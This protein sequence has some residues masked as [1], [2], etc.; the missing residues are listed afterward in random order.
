MAEDYRTE[1]VSAVLPIH[2]HGR[3]GDARHRHRG[4]YEAAEAAAQPT[5]DAA[6]VASILGL[7]ESMVTPRVLDA[8]AGLVSEIER[9]RWHDQQFQRREQYLEQ[10]S[11]RHSVV[12]A[13][14]R[15]AFVRE[16]ECF[17]ATGQPHGVLV[18][19]H[20]D[21]IERLAGVQGLAAGEGALRH[22]CG[23]LIGS[24]R[25]SDMVGL[26]S[27][28]DFAALLPG[29]DITHARGKLDEVAGRINNPSFVWLGQPVPLRLG[30]GLHVTQPGESA[31]TALGAVD[32]ARRGLDG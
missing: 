7:P 14:N 9:L 3:E 13:L 22:V 21:G 6:D 26:L 23:I 12:P 32:R 30:Y 17:L 16:L 8:V 15:R 19:V 2:E 28:S 10:L 4:P 11:D 31:E 1:R 24:L 29:A 27:G 18:M 5:R 20:V 25:Q